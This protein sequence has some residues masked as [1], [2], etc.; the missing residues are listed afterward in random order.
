VITKDDP[1]L[2]SAARTFFVLAWAKK[3]EEKGT[4][5]H[6]QGRDLFD[7]APKTP[8]GA[9]VYAAYFFGMLEHANNKS[10]HQLVRE[11]ADADCF[12]N[13]LRKDNYEKYKKYANDFAHYLVMM[14]IGHGVSWFDDHEEFE[15]RIPD[16]ED[17]EL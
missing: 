15:L 3:K 11:A 10:V 6:W 8:F 12:N 5:K 1:M 16:V 13:P 4:P 9:V 14:A 2:L 7:L 17:Y